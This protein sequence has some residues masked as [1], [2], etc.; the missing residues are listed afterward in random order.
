M[1][2]VSFAGTGALLLS[3]AAY[4]TFH[5]NSSF[6]GDVMTRLPAAGRT[7]A[8]TFDDGPN[9]EA[10]PRLLDTLVEHDVRATF[11]LLGRHVARWPALAQR[12]ASEG[13]LIGNHGFAHRRL[14][15]A[16]PARARRD[17]REGRAAILDACGVTTHH[18]RAPHG[19][20]SPFVPAA[21]RAAGE[22]TVGWT[23]GV[24]D[25]DCPGVA[26]IT[27]RV[28]KGVDPGSIVLL[29]DGDGYDPLGDRLQTVAAVDAII[30]A[31]RGQ[32]YSFA[33]LPR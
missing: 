27:H 31:L 17:V 5:R 21:V 30:P 19:F 18:F 32:G 13:H 14:H 6:F 26:E 33:V 23:L 25:S 8:L 2:Q 10:T 12:I 4:G 22:R 9:P 24:R 15:F 16:G 7:V 29:H 20:R 28:M 11:F 3:A 1:V